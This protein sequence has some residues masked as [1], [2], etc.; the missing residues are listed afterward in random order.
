MF[1]SDFCFQNCLSLPTLAIRSTSIESPN[2]EITSNIPSEYSDL[3]EVF[4]KGNAAKL[5]PHRTYDCAI[6]RV[7]NATW[8]KSRV[9]PLNQEEERAMD[10][11][12]QEAVGKGFIMPST[13]PAASRFFFREVA[14]VDDIDLLP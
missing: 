3:L 7:E 4:S 2:I 1:W 9:Y 11:C 10:T 6:D 5:P 14:Y 12:S 8:L 13:Y